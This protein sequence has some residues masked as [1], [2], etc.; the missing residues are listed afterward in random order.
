MRK[1]LVV[2]LM[3]EVELRFTLI[4]ASENLL[5]SFVF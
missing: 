3:T 4:T 2:I 5:R 1:L